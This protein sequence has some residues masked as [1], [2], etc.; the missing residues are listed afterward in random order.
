MTDVCFQ[1]IL[2][3]KMTL[4]S[5]MVSGPQNPALSNNTT[6]LHDIIVTQWDCYIY[7]D[8]VIAYHGSFFM[9]SILSDG[10]SP[11]SYIYICVFMCVCL[12]VCV[13]YEILTIILT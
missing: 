3:Q 12:C 5:A 7:A 13:H 2:Y 4:G 10:D 8:V 11:R 9:Y 1:Q 6:R